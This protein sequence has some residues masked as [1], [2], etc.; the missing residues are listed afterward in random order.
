[1]TDQVTFITKETVNHT[2]EDDDGNIVVSTT[3]HPWSDEE[4]LDRLMQH[5]TDIFS[6]PVEHAKAVLRPQGNYQEIPMGLIEEAA[7]QEIQNAAI[8]H[9]NPVEEVDHVAQSPAEKEEG[10]AP[11]EAVGKGPQTGRDARP[12]RKNNAKSK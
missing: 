5:S 7:E 3:K 9:T 12:A 1:M 2:T 10:K 6:V 8:P 11:T 4:L